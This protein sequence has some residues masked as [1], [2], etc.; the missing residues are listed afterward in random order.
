MNT[1][2]TDPEILYE[3]A[4]L[5]RAMTTSLEA[6]DPIA[7][8]RAQER[9]A[10]LTWLREMKA[11]RRGETLEHHTPPRYIW[12]TVG[13]NRVRNRHAD[14]DGKVFAWSRPPATGH[15]GDDHNCRCWAEPYLGDDP[16]FA[17]Q[18]LITAINDGPKR[19]NTEL[20]MK[21][22]FGPSND[23]TLS[24]IGY[25]RDII[26][27][28]DRSFGAYRRAN[29]QIVDKAKTSPLGYF[30]Y[31][32]ENVYEFGGVWGTTLYSLGGSTVKGTFE[33][34]SSFNGNVLVIK[35]IIT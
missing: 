11:N 19:T 3:Q 14:N 15:P 28:Y 1:P 34:E 22:Y 29:Q 12:R 8:R 17:R 30:I 16:V 2:D 20:I 25:L 24:Q 18:T 6:G 27:A 26:N 33:G 21:Y 31:E 10:H 4:R 7:Y 23:V 13:D 9:F 5:L 35:G 32:F